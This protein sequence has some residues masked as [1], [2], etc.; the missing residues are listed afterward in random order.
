MNRKRRPFFF[1]PL[2]KYNDFILI[3][4]VKVFRGNVRT[5][6]VTIWVIKVMGLWMGW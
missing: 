4:Y 1:T 6:N 2:L 5:G 3:S